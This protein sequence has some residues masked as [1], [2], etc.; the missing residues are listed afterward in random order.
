MNRWRCVHLDQHRHR[1]VQQPVLALTHRS[2][3]LVQ[4]TE[5]GVIAVGT[6]PLGLFR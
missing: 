6:A 4:I 1:A 5:K 3:A 2:L